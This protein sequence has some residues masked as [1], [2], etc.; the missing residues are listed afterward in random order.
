MNALND[1]Y[2]INIYERYLD[3]KNSNKLE[4]DNNDL[5]KIF[6]YYSCLKLSEEYKKPFY[7]YDD[8][9]PTF[10]EL[11]KMSRNDTGIDL[12]DLDKT[13]VQCKLRKN[14]LSWKECSTFFGS[15]NIFNKELN[16]AIIRWDNLIITR[17]NDCILSENLLERKELF[18]DRPYI[19]QEL[20]QFCENLIINP[21]KYPVINNSFNLRD[22]QQE[23]I[24]M[25]TQNK[26]NVI[27]NLPTG[28][29]KNS[30]IIYSFQEKK[31]Y[32]KSSDVKMQNIK[33]GWHEF[34][35][36]N[37]WKFIEQ[38]QLLQEYLPWE[39]MKECRFPDK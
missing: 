19:K 25:I 1:K 6:E 3:L 39:E 27:I 30:V 37:I 11:N 5:W 4:L 28:T 15:Q 36:K 16:K 29:G 2:T 20:I 38:D 35:I 8:I 26:K 18:I 24:N 10:K 22:Y 17:N 33:E 7:E 34:A 32:L 12:S 31:K 14:T 13:I 21:P 9:D 23:S